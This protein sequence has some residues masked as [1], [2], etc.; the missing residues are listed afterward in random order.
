MADN[1][2]LAYMFVGDQVYQ[3]FVEGFQPKK[4]SFVWT[5]PIF[6]NGIHTD[7]SGNVFRIVSQSDGYK[8][9]PKEF[10][11]FIIGF[12][13]EPKFTLCDGWQHSD[14]CY[15]NWFKPAKGQK[16]KYQCK[17]LL[18]ENQYCQ[19]IDVPKVVIEK[20]HPNKN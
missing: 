14:N 4:H 13:N 10:H 11:D 12:C 7:G 19:I 5:K 18:A 17:I 15:P 16:L 1:Y 9:Y 6:K 3:I 20:I 2:K 8:K